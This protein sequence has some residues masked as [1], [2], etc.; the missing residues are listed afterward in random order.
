[1][2]LVFWGVVVVA[3]GYLAYSGMIAAWSWIA[4]QNAV[5]EIISKD[6]IESVPIPDVRGRVLKAANEAG[7]PITEK[8][9]V[10][11]REDKGVQ[12][13]IIWTVPVITVKGESVLA[14]PLSVK[15]ST[16]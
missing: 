10:V 2:R 9:V 1:M 8:D 6:G 13:E 5:D 15:R 12:V 16:K 4:V 14:V 3:F 11:T 7:V